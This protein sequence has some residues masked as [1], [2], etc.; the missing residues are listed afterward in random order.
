LT[1]DIQITAGGGNCICS[2]YGYYAIRIAWV[3]YFN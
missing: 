1:F 2:N 3:I